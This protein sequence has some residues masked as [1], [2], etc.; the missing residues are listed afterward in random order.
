MAVSI[1]FQDLFPDS[2][3]ERRNHINYF[4]FVPTTTSVWVYGRHNTY[5]TIDREKLLSILTDSGIKYTNIISPSTVTFVNSVFQITANNE[6]IVKP[7]A[8]GGMQPTY[9]NSPVADISS[10][11]CNFIISGLTVGKTYYIRAFTEYDD[12]NI[13]IGLGI[14]STSKALISLTRL[15]RLPAIG[16]GYYKHPGTGARDGSAYSAYLRN[17]TVFAGKTIQTKAV[18]AGNSV[19]AL[20]SA[21]GA[22]SFVVIKDLGAK[23]TTVTEL[24]TY[25]E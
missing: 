20:L 24:E 13:D 23:D 4:S 10:A 8:D 1:T 5:P 15:T 25:L 18:V 9:T 21:D 6:I 17:K 12:N 3:D 11:T 2:T 7:D 16:G 19:T 22:E 14:Y